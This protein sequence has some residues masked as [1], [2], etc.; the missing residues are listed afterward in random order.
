MAALLTPFPVLPWRDVVTLQEANLGWVCTWHTHP[1]G[2]DP[3]GWQAKA[4]V[5]YLSWSLRTAPGTWAQWWDTALSWAGDGSVVAAYPDLPRETV[6]TQPWP[7]SLHLP[8]VAA[9]LAVVDP[10]VRLLKNE[11]GPQLHLRQG[12]EAR[13]VCLPSPVARDILKELQFARGD[14]ADVWTIVHR[15]LPDAWH[16][17]FRPPPPRASG[18]VGKA[19]VGRQ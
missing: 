7:V 4:V 6:A 14:G 2:M 10:E 15:Q 17:T 1:A 18:G 5:T 12:M 13:S 16:R 11:D 8:T 9:R 19:R 3:H